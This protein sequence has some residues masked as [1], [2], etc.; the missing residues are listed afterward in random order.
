M[1]RW[2]ETGVAASSRAAG[3]KSVRVT[4]AHA[5]ASAPPRAEPRVVAPDR[6]PVDCAG[7]RVQTRGGSGGSSPPPG[8][9]GSRAARKDR[10]RHGTGCQ[11]KPDAPPR[12]PG[13]TRERAVTTR[14]P[15]TRWPAS[16]PRIPSPPHCGPSAARIPFGP[17]GRI[18]QSRAVRLTEHWPGGNGRKGTRGRPYFAFEVEVLGPRGAHE[19]HSG[20]S[21]FD[22]V[23]GPARRAGDEDRPR[24]P[25]EVYRFTGGRRTKTWL[26]WHSRLIP[27]PATAAATA[28]AQA[29]TG[30]TDLPSSRPRSS[31][32]GGRIRGASP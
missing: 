28:A 2:Q 8:R 16:P 10:H 24:T 12:S 13:R 31:L 32:V 17:R 29:A 9:Y 5:I 23:E 4:R 1:P 18:R 6:H 27:Q 25:G 3:P 20:R 14:F 11:G 21:G 7:T 19:V 26:P 30:E 22:V 15:S